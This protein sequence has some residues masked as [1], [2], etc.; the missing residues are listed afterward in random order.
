MALTFQI[1][2]ATSPSAKAF[3]KYIKTLDFIKTTPKTNEFVLTPEHLEQLNQRR[4]N[5]MEGKSTTHSWEDTQAFAR[6]SGSK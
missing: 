5:R 4:N 6:A 2:D 1:E 3:L